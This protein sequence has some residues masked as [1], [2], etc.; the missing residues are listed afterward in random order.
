MERA[1]PS[2]GEC[3]RRQTESDLNHALRHHVD[4]LLAY[5]AVLDALANSGHASLALPARPGDRI[6]KLAFRLVCQVKAALKRIN[7]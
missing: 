6:A 7:Q 1:F 5:L 2:L 4:P 3:Y